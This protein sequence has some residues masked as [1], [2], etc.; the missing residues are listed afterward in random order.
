[1][2]SISL[3]LTLIQ[4]LYSLRIIYVEVEN[5]R[6]FCSFILGIENFNLEKYM[7]KD[8]YVATFSLQNA[9]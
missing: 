1:M 2:V 6:G 5:F 3:V 9:L 4:L 8:M 7:S